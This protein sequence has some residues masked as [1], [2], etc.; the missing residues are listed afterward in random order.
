MILCGVGRVGR[1]LT[2]L[3]NARPGYRVVAAYT[4]N[5]ALAGQDIG[6]LAGIGALGVVAQG[7]RDTA[8]A[9]PGDVLVVATTSFLRDVAAD[10]RVGVEHR[11][12]V[13]TTAEE[14][15]FPWLADEQLA[16]GLDA[17]AKTEG[18]SILGTGLNPGFIFDALLLTAT[19]VAWNIERI[20]VKRVVDVS[21][22]SATIQRRLGIGF[23]R[24]AFEEGVASG[25]I[26]GHI[27]F[28]QTFS[29]ASACLGHALESIEKRFEPLIATTAYANDHLKVAVGETAGFVQHT[30]GFVDG[31]PWMVAEFVAHV[32]PASIGLSVEDSIAIEG[33]NSLNL[34]IN[35]SCN[36]QRG[37][38]AML[39]NCI[40]RVVE[41]RPGF[42]TIADLPLPHARPT[43]AL[44]EGGGGD[45]GRSGS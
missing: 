26:T 19:G 44:D 29:L 35:P 7:D 36:P 23:T 15:S 43:R 8:L 24:S 45:H 32:D 42:L 40:P 14:A 22:F 38:V 37:A 28:V 17:L 34:V 30:L 20:R 12:N 39:A 16:R 10:L 9:V 18:V 2:R 3:L 4:R 6:L 5:P 11:L 25:S 1:D 27:G 13:L 33:H 31:V 41:A 21:R